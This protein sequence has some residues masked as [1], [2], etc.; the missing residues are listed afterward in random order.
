[1]IAQVSL[2]RFLI[3]VAS[4]EKKRRPRARARG[5]QCIVRSM[6]YAA[7]LLGV[8]DRQ[9]HAKTA[10]WRS[11]MSGMIAISN[12]L[13]NAPPRMSVAVVPLAVAPTES[14]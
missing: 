4:R 14:R 7:G 13:V 12:R 2:D 10:I 11:V 5:R 9:Q 6:G 3:I 1:M 8:E